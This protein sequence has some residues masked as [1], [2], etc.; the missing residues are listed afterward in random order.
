VTRFE[1]FVAAR[2]LRIRRKEA[3]I[4]VVTLISVTGVAAGVAAL[5]I[6]LA[7]NNGFRNTLQRD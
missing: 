3:V 2:Y 1:L 6:S 7:I 5:I 4:S